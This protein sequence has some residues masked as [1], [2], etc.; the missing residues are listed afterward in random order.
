MISPPLFVLTQTGRKSFKS[1]QEI[2]PDDPYILKKQL[3]Q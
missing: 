1:L 3:F 2:S